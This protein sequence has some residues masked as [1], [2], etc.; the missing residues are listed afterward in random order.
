M[1]IL[2]FMMR[3]LL[4]LLLMLQLFV[5]REASL[6]VALFMMVVF[7][8]A[9]M[10]MIIRHT[11]LMIKHMSFFVTLRQVHGWVISHNVALVDE[12]GESPIVVSFLSHWVSG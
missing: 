11:W 2:V 6:S 1:I 10:T 5:N 9:S 4:F 12:L 3:I 7:W 8:A